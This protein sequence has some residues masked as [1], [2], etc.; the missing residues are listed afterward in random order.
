MNRGVDFLTPLVTYAENC[1]EFEVTIVTTAPLQMHLSPLRNSIISIATDLWRK[2]RIV[3]KNALF[4][5]K[6]NFFINFRSIQINLHKGVQK[7]AH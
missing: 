6:L 7:G 4:N 3:T 2:I 5:E 1:T